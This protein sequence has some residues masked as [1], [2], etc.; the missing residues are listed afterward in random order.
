MFSFKQ[1]IKRLLNLD[2]QDKEIDEIARLE[3]LLA[4]NA[5][6]NDLRSEDPSEFRKILYNA[7]FEK[8]SPKQIIQAVG[9]EIFVIIFMGNIS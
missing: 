6:L 9:K 5:F 3:N 2:K 8:F 7:T 1:E 4:D